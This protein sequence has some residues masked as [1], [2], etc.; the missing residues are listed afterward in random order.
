MDTQRLTLPPFVFRSVA[1]CAVLFCACFPAGGQLVIPDDTPVTPSESAQPE[2]E[3]S[4]PAQQPSSPP[5]AVP[6]PQRSSDKV[7]SSPEALLA[8]A[9]ESFTVRG[10]AIHPKIVAEFLC[11]MA[12]RGDPLTVTMDVA[13]AQGTN[14]Y[15]CAG[16]LPDS[17]EEDVVMESDGTKYGYRWYGRLSNGLHVVRAWED[18]GH[19]A[20]PDSLFFVRFSL[21]R[22]VSDRKPAYDRLLM[23]VVG[24]H[25]PVL[26][27]VARAGDAVMIHRDGREDAVILK[28]AP[29]KRGNDIRPDIRE[30]LGTLERDFTVDGVHVHA[31]IVEEFNGWISDKGYPLSVAVDLQAAVGSNEYFSDAVEN[32][33]SGSRIIHEE[34]Y[35][36]YTWCGRMKN[37]VH[38]LR[39]YESGGGSGVFQSLFFV[40]FSADRAF[41]GDETPYDRLL[42]SAL[43]SYVLGDRSGSDIM[44]QDDEIMI[45]PDESGAPPVA[46]R[47]GP[48][49]LTREELS[50][51]PAP[52]ASPAAQPAPDLEDSAAATTPWKD[53]FAF[54]AL[55]CDARTVSG[56]PVLFG[57]FDKSV[58]VTLVPKQGDTLQTAETGST[59]KSASFD[60]LETEETP[61]QG[62]SACG[63]AAI[64]VVGEAACSLP[65]VTIMT[66]EEAG[67]HTLRAHRIL[68]KNAGNADVSSARRV[69]T[70]SVKA[71]SGLVYVVVCFEAAAQPSG[72]GGDRFAV[73]MDPG[74]ARGGSLWVACGEFPVFF[75]VGGQLYATSWLDACDNG[76]RCRMVHRITPDG[77]EE[78]Y[79]NS[80]LAT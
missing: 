22:G 80:D 74:G 34:G 38:V 73:I 47:I 69:S 64:A 58:P 4:P 53:A 14:E 46:L 55:N 5:A 61:L 8:E 23:T 13:Q 57:R 60:G 78:V 77:P 39:V 31:G 9:E 25:A 21:D 62:V 49:G 7:S 30:R 35:F 32:T 15:C 45:L 59:V 54:A 27:D 66:N 36:N 56:P 16:D 51:S 52:P 11:S 18:T 6:P 17:A 12:D 3:P 33:P 50:M 26:G 10:R 1:C 48:K 19:R 70:S 67:D 75:E 63:N 68:R 2:Q 20:H 76:V 40:A 72:G 44:V 71:S 65:S 28:P 41:K 42:L 37:G 24:W 29:P 43:G 79:S